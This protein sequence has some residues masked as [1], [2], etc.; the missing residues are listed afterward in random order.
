MGAPGCPTPEKKAYLTVSGAKRHMWSLWKK[1]KRP[2]RIAVRP[3]QCSC[4]M[5]HVGHGG[6]R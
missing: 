1:G 5:W 3:Y 4:G 2:D 6:P